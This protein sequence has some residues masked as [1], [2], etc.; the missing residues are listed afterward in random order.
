MLDHVFKKST[1]ITINIYATIFSSS[2]HVAAHG[3]TPLQACPTVVDGTL[4]IY[5]MLGV[6]WQQSRVTTRLASVHGR[7]PRGY[8]HPKQK[9]N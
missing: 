9:K 2:S 6:A 7:C 1:T 8:V 4:A 3:T 5:A